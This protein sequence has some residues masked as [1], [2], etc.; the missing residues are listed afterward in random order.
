MNNQ[1]NYQSEWEKLRFKFRF[2]FKE[3]ILYNLKSPI[4]LLGLSRRVLKLTI[5]TIKL[6]VRAFS[7]KRII[8]NLK[9]L[10]KNNVTISFI[11]PAIRNAT[12][13]NKT[14]VVF[15][16]VGDTSVI[17]QEE[18]DTLKRKYSKRPNSPLVS[19]IMPTWNRG[20]VVGRAIKSV[21]KQSYKNWE[22]IIV[23]DG[24]IDNTANVVAR[25]LRNKKIKYISM[26]HRGVSSSRN[27]GLEHAKGS[28]V[29]YLDSDNEWH[30]D[31]LLLSVNYMIDH[32]KDTCYCGLV[33]YDLDINKGFVRLRNFN[34]ASLLIDNY[35]DINVFIHKFDLVKEYG[36]FDDSLKRWVDWD[37]I[38]R[39]TAQSPPVVLNTILCYYYKKESLRSITQTQ[40][41]ANKFQVLNKHLIN[42]DSLKERK[43]RAGLVSI[44][45]PLFNNVTYTRRCIKSIVEKTQYQPYEIIL[46]NNGSYDGTNSYIQKVVKSHNAIIPISNPQNYGF[47]LGCNIGASHAKGEY[48]LFLNNDTKVTDGWLEYLVQTM[49]SNN[50][51]GAV[52]SKLVYPKTETIQHAGMVFSDRSKIAQHIYKDFPAGAPEVN[53]IREFQTLTAACILIRADI[54]YRV[55]GFPT[56][57]LNGGED[58]ALCFIIKQ[59]GKRLIYQPASK[60]Y[61]FEGKTEGRFGGS[62]HNRKVWIEEWGD[63]VIR[64]DK[65]FFNEDG[66]ITTGYQREEG[67]RDEQLTYYQPRLIRKV[68][69]HGLVKKP[70]KELLILRSQGIG[71]GV[72]ATPFIKYLKMIWPESVIHLVC[73]QRSL[74]YWQ[75]LTVEGL[76]VHSYNRFDRK[77]IPLCDALIVP[78]LV[79]HRWKSY[80][81]NARYCFGGFGEPASNKIHESEWL[82]EAA[83]PLIEDGS[84]K[85]SVPFPIPLEGEKPRHILL[86]EGKR[87]IAIFNGCWPDFPQ[88]QLPFEN[89]VRIVRVLGRLAQNTNRNLL[90]LGTKMERKMNREVIRAVP[91]ALRSHVL[92][93][94]ITSPSI[95]ETVFWIESSD[96]VISTDSSIGHLT[97]AQ[98]VPLLLLTGPT[99]MIKNRPIGPGWIKVLTHGDCKYRPCYVKYPEIMAECPNTKRK[100]K[101]MHFSV[102]EVVHNVTRLLSENK[103]SGSS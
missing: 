101:C 32:Q 58:S 12:N 9:H 7:L 75:S 57:Y 88:R 85:Y 43:V 17:L 67:L 81:K 36:G 18:V 71:N 62:L 48:L 60:V 73:E 46:V 54:F 23:D 16:F 63:S 55:G 87:S 97:A 29:S 22:L 70:N 19:I 76:F 26:P 30:K 80:E 83:V 1:R 20:S 56:Q 90:L 66:Y 11:P 28:I 27:T 33:Y 91:L 37:L 84:W 102:D 79:G 98:G 77:R 38:L 94:S 3:R 45:I 2:Q 100:A 8:P 31:F 35:I 10:P 24:S 99:D 103:N 52:G 53:K 68:E 82:F 49:K 96:I 15:P 13:A 41:L 59:L 74:A 40:S 50:S 61:H 21:I 86:K 65:M 69:L 95:R 78:R 92:D 25:F 4:R 47:S 5:G 64:D 34:M 39:Y 93:I 44:I 89:F 72:L 14:S 42:W 51:I 6:K